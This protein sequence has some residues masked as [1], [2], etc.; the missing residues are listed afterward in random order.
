[1][2]AHDRQ[3][4]SRSLDRSPDR[5]AAD[6]VIGRAI[7]RAAV[8]PESRSSPGEAPLASG[9]VSALYGSRPGVPGPTP[10]AAAEPARTARTVPPDENTTLGLAAAS[11]VPTIP[12]P[13]A[14]PRQRAR[15]TAARRY[16]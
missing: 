10:G 14:S 4:R 6:R 1:M 2:A 9:A 15:Q 8:P 11:N 16:S 3:H 7:G 5:A 12:E 13:V